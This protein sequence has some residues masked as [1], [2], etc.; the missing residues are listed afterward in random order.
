MK[1]TSQ[2]LKGKRESMDISLVE[3]S[4]A[5]KI[6]PRTLQAIEAADLQHLPARSFLRGFVKSYAAFLKMDVDEVL[7]IFSD[8][9]TALEAPPV[10]STLPPQESPAPAEAVTSPAR[11]ISAP[12]RSSPR[13]SDENSP[14]SSTSLIPEGVSTSKKFAIALGLFV[15][16][17]TVGIVYRLVAKYEREG[18]AEKAPMALNKIEEDDAPLKPEIKADTVSEKEPATKPAADPKVPE[19]KAAE[20]KPEGKPE[21][22]PAEVKATEAKP[23]VEAK[24]AEGKPQDVK[25]AAPAEAKPNDAAVATPTAPKDPTKRVVQEVI[26]EALDKVDVGFKVNNGSLEKVTLMPDQVHTIKAA[27]LIG[28]ELSDGGAV[29]II[30]N[31]REVGVP[32]DLGK[33]KKIQFP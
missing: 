32:G 6:T 29:N 14:S 11:D 17:G 28:L 22:K 13:L 3:V 30:V 26:I 27:G 2:I 9:M 19:T 15:L 24:A 33:P 16:L 8:E 21:T 25:A 20:I 12:V 4:I 5:T 18:Q 7:K 31:G 1:V 10:P 23:P